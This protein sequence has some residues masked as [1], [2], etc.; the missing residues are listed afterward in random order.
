MS[1]LTSAYNLTVGNSLIVAGNIQQNQQALNNLGN[2][3]TPQIQTIDII[4]EETTTNNLNVL[5]DLTTNNLTVNGNTTL[6]ENVNLSLYDTTFYDLN[7]SNSIKFTLSGVDYVL[8]KNELKKLLTSASVSYVDSSITTAINNLLGPDLDVSYDT[9]KEIQLILQENEA[10]ITTL[11][12]ALSTKTTLNEIQAYENTF[13]NENIFMSNVYMNN[14]L[15]LNGLNVKSQIENANNQISLNTIEIAENITRLDNIDNQIIDIGTDILNL[16]TTVSSNEQKLTKIF[17]EDQIV[18]IKDQ[19]Y[20]YSTELEDEF[21]IFKYDFEQEDLSETNLKNHVNNDYTRGIMNTTSISSTIYKWGYS[22]LYTNNS[23]FAHNLVSSHPG[24]I[25]NSVMFWVYGLSSQL[26]LNPTL[27][28]FYH[29]NNTNHNFYLH[30]NAQGDGFIYWKYSATIYMYNININFTDGIMKHIAIIL[31]PTI[32][33]HLYLNGVLHYTSPQIF[34]NNSLVARIEL[35]AKSDLTN[36]GYNGYFDDFRYYKRVLTQSEILNIFKFSN[37]KLIGDSSYFNKIDCQFIN[38]INKQDLEFIKTSQTQISEISDGIINLSNQLNDSLIDKNQLSTDINIVSGLYHDLAELTRGI[39]YDLTTDTTTI[40]NNLIITKQLTNTELQNATQDI[41]LIKADIED[42][43]DDIQTINTRITD[44]NYSNDITTIANG[45]TVTGD[46]IFPTTYTSGL[47]ANILVSNSFIQFQTT[48]NNIST[49]TFNYLSG[50]SS[51]IQTQ[52]NNILSRIAG[53][54]YSGNTTSITGNLSFTGNLNSISTTT[55]NYLSGVT[56]NI[57][58]QFNNILNRIT[59]ISFDNN[60]TTI[61]GNLNTTN[62]NTTNLNFT[63]SINNVI[64]PFELA[65]LNGITQN[66]NDVINQIPKFLFRHVRIV[67]SGSSISGLIYIPE[68][69]VNYAVFPSYYYGFTGSGG[70]YNAIDSSSALKQIIISNILPGSFAYH[71]EKS[72]GNNINLDIHFLIVYDL[73]Y[74][75]YV[76]TWS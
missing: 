52:F 51:N 5:T 44:I 32:G 33:I 25:G 59:N 28:N 35:G 68:F 42:I 46:C 21:Y 39:T 45:L 31:S 61:T 50:V 19:I 15:I 27:L 74:L 20:L 24:N 9:L 1:N 69:S 14:D 40:D 66:I 10:N 75:D 55:F 72:T 41:V 37:Y 22:S 6:L 62:L 54:N 47:Y 7:L 4:T 73:D 8:T 67:G 65:Q 3:T 11:L 63:G 30:I 43:E 13:T 58:T 12:S 2:I 26:S 36:S 60:T 53:I 49:T 17:Y 56:S 23:Y 57:Q 64:T 71:L 34:Y 76:K 29:T 70:T 38:G 48:I 18:K 16:N